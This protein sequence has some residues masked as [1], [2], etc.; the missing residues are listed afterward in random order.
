MLVY[1]IGNPGRQDDALGPLLVEEVRRHCSP[2]VVDVDANYQLNVEDALLISRYK[3]VIFVD[4]ADTDAA[5]GALTDSAADG[6]VC[7]LQ[8]VMEAPTGAFSTHAVLPGAIVSLAR[9][10]Y[11]AQPKVWLLTVR[12]YHWEPNK[13]LSEDGRVSF[14]QGRKILLETIET[15]GGSEDGE[16]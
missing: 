8:P 3:V 6:A 12:G 9:E 11:G 10:L 1:G 4:A 7:H 14:L 16:H 5:D 15:M 13:P 2:A